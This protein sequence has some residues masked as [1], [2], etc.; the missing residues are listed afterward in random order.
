MTMV[1]ICGITKE[2]HALAAAEAGA[3]FIGLVFTKSPR[4]ITP[5]QANKITA[6]LKQNR[7][8]APATIGVFVNTPVHVVNRV[9][10]FCHLDYVQLSGDE[11]M[12]YC[13]ELTPPVFKVIKVGQQRQ[14]EQVCKD[15]A[16]W[17]KALSDH[18][19]I[20]LLDAYDSEKFGGTGKQLDWDVVKPV[21]EKF[22]IIIAGGLNPGNVSPV[23]EK[24]RPWGVDVSSGVETNGEKDVN[25]IKAFIKA[26]READSDNKYQGASGK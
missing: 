8:A 10:E 21:A 2:E 25:K 1:K 24:V 20:F 18:K 19:Y 9:A 11:N 23:V 5:A 13:K 16:A 22:K 4:Q 12:G 17:N 3:D 15:L 14:S 26:V 7:D 6:A